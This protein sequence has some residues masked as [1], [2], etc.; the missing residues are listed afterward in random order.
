M[1]RPGSAVQQHGPANCRLERLRQLREREPEARITG[2]T[3]EPMH[4]ARNGFDAARTTFLEADVNA[5]LR[6]FQ[7][8]EVMPASQARSATTVRMVFFMAGGWYEPSDELFVPCAG[9]HDEPSAL[10][11]HR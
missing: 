1:C 10:C 6:Q 8:S 2:F 9:N 11:C 3:V 7:A 5:S 4:V